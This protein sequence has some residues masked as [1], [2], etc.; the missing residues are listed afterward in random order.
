LISD[1]YIIIVIISY[2]LF[3][4]RIFIIATKI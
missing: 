1:F 3:L 2:P 4:G